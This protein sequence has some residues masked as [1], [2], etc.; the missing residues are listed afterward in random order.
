MLSGIPAVP[1]RNKGSKCWSLGDNTGITLSLSFLLRK[2]SKGKVSAKDKFLAMWTQFNDQKRWSLPLKPANQPKGSKEKVWFMPVRDSCTFVLA[3][4]LKEAQHEA[5]IKALTFYFR[6]RSPKQGE[7][8][9]KGEEASKQAK[10]ALW[11]DT[12]VRRLL[13]C[14]EPRRNSAVSQKASLLT[15]L[16]DFQEGSCAGNTPGRSSENRGRRSFSAWLPLAS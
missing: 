14:N 7:W 11:E 8:G 15:L 6:D 9:K 3:Q 13:L 1:T 16:P 2:T 5:R 12:S 10:K 4:V